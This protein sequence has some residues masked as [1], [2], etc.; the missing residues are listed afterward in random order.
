MSRALSLSLSAVMILSVSIG[1]VLG[2]YDYK[3]LHVAY[4]QNGAFRYAANPAF[5]FGDWGRFG[6]VG[7]MSLDKEL[8]A[9]KIE[10]HEHA[11]ALAASPNY[12]RRY[13]ILLALDD[14]MDDALLQVKRL[15][16]LTPGSFDRQYTWLVAMCDE[17]N[18]SLSDFKSRLLR[19]YG[20]PKHDKGTE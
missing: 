9:E 11:I 6:L 2:Y 1:L 3:K 13:I 15:R 16:G 10:M 17:Q 8:L 18:D 14:R 4:E 20:Q 12:V 7:M 5:I 19:T